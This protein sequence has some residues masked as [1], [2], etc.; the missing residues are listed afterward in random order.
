M[1]KQIASLF[2]TESDPT[3]WPRMILCG[4][5]TAVPLFVGLYQGHVALS[6]YGA[7]SGYLL[8]LNDHLGYLKHRLKVITLTILFLAGGFAS[9]Y[10]LQGEQIAYGLIL[11]SL[12]YWLGVLA[13]EGAELERGTLF[14]TLGMVIANSSPKLPPGTLSPLLFY[15]GLGYACMIIGIP[16]LDHIK[17][18]VPDPYKGLRESFRNSITIQVTKH[19]HALSYAIVALLSIWI[20][21]YF[22]IERGYWVTVTVLLVMKPDRK[23]SLYTTIQRLIGTLVAALFCDIVIQNVHATAPLVTFI[24]GCAFAVPWAIK[25]NYLLMAFLVTVMVVFL[26][27]LATADRSDTHIPLL[28]LQATLIGCGLSALGTLLSKTMDWLRLYLKQTASS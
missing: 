4:L 23:Q 20:V 22:H 27:E 21:S 9:G 6:I 26:L 5:A 3:P 18:H 15:V 25:R 10:L 2:K 11:T 28:R 1:R 12:V 24:V 17:K 19:I 13:G 14:G 8:A 7:I 16:V